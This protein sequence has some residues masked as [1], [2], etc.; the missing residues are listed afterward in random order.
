MPHAHTLAGARI[1][2]ACSGRAIF[3]CANALGVFYLRALSWL[4]LGERA[5]RL[6]QRQCNYTYVSMCIFCVICIFHIEYKEPGHD[7][8][9]VARLL[10]AAWMQL[11]HSF[12]QHTHTMPP[13]GWLVMM[14]CDIPAAA[15][16]SSHSR[17]TAQHNQLPICICVAARRLNHSPVY[18][19][20]RWFEIEGEMV[21]NIHKI[22]IFKQNF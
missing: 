6:L 15:H 12:I 4:P 17:L 14:M 5:G 19:S 10:T 18:T 8:A 16:S 2:A 20:E 22:A 11:L 3:V 13:P 21:N 9:R 7:Q 1:S